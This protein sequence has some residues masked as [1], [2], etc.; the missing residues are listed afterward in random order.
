MGV[1]AASLKAN[2]G[3]VTQNGWYWKGSI[4]S[5][6]GPCACTSTSF[7]S[8][9]AECISPRTAATTR[10]WFQS[11]ERKRLCSSPSWAWSPPLWIGMG[12]GDVGS[13]TKQQQYLSPCLCLRKSTFLNSK[14]SET[15]PRVSLLGP[16]LLNVY[17]LTAARPWLVGGWKVF[18]TIGTW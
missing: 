5:A 7:V 3:T 15:W 10:W 12:T 4:H 2:F 6:C 13:Q 16:L 8:R 9:P 1:P 18:E 17:S 14:Q 11:T